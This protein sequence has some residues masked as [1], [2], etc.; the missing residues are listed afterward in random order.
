MDIVIG[1]IYSV[2]KILSFTWWI[3]LPIVLIPLFH[4]YWLVFMREKFIRKLEWSFLEIKVPKDI[5]KTPKAMEQVF[6]AMYGNYSHHIKTVYKYTEGHV[7]L[8][9][10]FEIVG[11]AGGVHFYV[12]VPT[13]LRNMVESAI[14]SEYPDAE[15]HETED[16]AD[17][18]PGSMPN[19]TYELWGAQFE[20]VKVS[21]YPIR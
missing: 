12:V 5:L 9:L 11:H 19:K 10:S 16:Y 3:F 2:L 7:D 15:I 4:Q 6:S 21:C 17:L 20:F 13:K 14:F 1:A 18:L 8:W